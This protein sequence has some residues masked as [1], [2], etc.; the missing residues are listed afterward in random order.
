MIERPQEPTQDGM[1]TADM[2]DED[3]EAIFAMAIRI[4]SYYATKPND[5]FHVNEMEK[6]IVDEAFKL[7]YVV[8]VHTA[9]CLLGLESPTLEVV[10]RVAGHEF[11]KHGMDH[12][13]KGWE[14]AKSITTGG[15]VEMRRKLH[16]IEPGRGMKDTGT[17]IG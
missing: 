12:E 16:V 4:Q 11:H 1:T 13:R 8:R 10:D 6:R 5:K 9:R 7:G 3:V 14:I 2:Y 17:F 15:E